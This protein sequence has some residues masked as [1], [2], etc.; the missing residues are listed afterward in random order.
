MFKAKI[1]VA[2]AVWLTMPNGEMIESSDPHTIVVAPQGQ[3]LLIKA[4]RVG[5]ATMSLKVG[6]VNVDSGEVEVVP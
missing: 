5:K 6:G 2:T 1:K 3:D 4:L